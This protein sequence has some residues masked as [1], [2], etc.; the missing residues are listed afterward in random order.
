MTAGSRQAA[1]RPR[2]HGRGAV[3]RCVRRYRRFLLALHEAPDGDAVGSN[4]AMAAALAALGK[5]AQVVSADPV[6]RLFD[7]LPGVDEV[8]EPGEATGPWDVALLL[9][10]SDADRVGGAATLVAQAAVVC[11]VDHHKTNQGFGHVRWVDPAAAATG[12]LVYHLLQG[13]RAL[14]TPAMAQCLYTAISTDTGSFRFEQTTAATHRIAARLIELG[15]DPAQVVNNV[16]DTRS[17]ASL[18]LLRLALER[19]EVHPDGHVAWITLPRPVL[20]SAG[21]SDEDAEGLVNYAR[22]VEGVEVGLLFREVEDGRVKV[23]LRSRARVDVADLASVMGGGGHPRAA[24]C[25]L[26]GGLEVAVERVVSAAA[27][28]ARSGRDH[29]TGG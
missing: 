21:A 10:C 8:L 6:P 16:Y 28:A 19:L 1:G 26:D 4:L 15:A 18:R 12:E 13:L 27:L 5:E 23:S 3:L 2:G 22:S 7:F 25:L 24:G 17:L 11:N 9:D 20:E 14:W 29:G